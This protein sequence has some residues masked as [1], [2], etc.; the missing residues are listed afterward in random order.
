[1]SD[2]LDGLSLQRRLVDDRRLAAKFQ[3]ANGN[4][5]F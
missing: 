3:N 1:M 4:R 5:V 2:R